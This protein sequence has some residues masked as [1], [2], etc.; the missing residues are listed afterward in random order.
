MGDL[1]IIL[2]NDELGSHL[3][4]LRFWWRRGIL[5]SLDNDI[6][7]LVDGGTLRHLHF[8][9]IVGLDVEGHQC[10]DECYHQTNLQKKTFLVFQI[11]F[12]TFLQ[13]HIICF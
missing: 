13:F 6:L 5:G 7:N 2:H 11:G 12:G 8:F 9:G 4:G 1:G 10:E 3:G